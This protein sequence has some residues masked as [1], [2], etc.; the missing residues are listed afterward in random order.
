MD[1]NQMLNGIEEWMRKTLKIGDIFIN[2]KTIRADLT[3]LKQQLQRIERTMTTT[4]Q[5]VLTAIADS[6]AA[7]LAALEE[8]KLEILEAIDTAAQNPTAENFTA[9]KSAVLERDGAIRQAILGIIPTVPS[10]VDPL[11]PVDPT[12]PPPPTPEPIPTP[13]PLPPNV[14]PVV[15][16]IITPS[17]D[18]VGVDGGSNIDIDP[19]AT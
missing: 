13:E 14:D 9:I 3:A 17:P 12:V 16:V 18:D 1:E 4:F 7:T 6:G 19:S 8:E 11:P 10:P 15:P 2:L 5:E